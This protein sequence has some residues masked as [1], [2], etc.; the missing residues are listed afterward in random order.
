VPAGGAARG[1]DRAAVLDLTGAWSHGV[2]V[3]SAEW[4]SAA[5]A[6]FERH[7]RLER[8]R[9]EHTVRAYAADVASLLEHAER[10]GRSDVA[11]IDLSVLRS[12]LARLRSQGMARATLARRASAARTFTA[13]AAETGRL[14]A[15]PGSALASPRLGRP[16][17][18]ALSSAQVGEL[19]APAN[20]GS[21]PVATA[22]GRRDTAL[23]ELLYATGARVAELCGAD[24]SDID[25]ERRV[26]R[27]FGK[28]AKERVV[29]F[30]TPAARALHTWI[31]NGRPVL[32]TGASGHALF[33]GARGGRLDQRAARAA[34]TQAA[35]RSGLSHVTPHTLRHSAATHLVEGGADLR[36]VQELLGHASLATTQ[37][38]THVTAER[39]KAT[40]DR[41]HPRA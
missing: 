38:Y 17:P 23:L 31:A 11:S 1:G 36:S 22:L 28:G 10:M 37:I 34:V 33:L 5:L 2:V 41:A 8:G 30:G 14:L 21:E 19:I 25:D 26:L 9:S 24:L 12:W 40:Y 32:A 16:V 35:R 27:V 20:P 13:W 3:T 15:D 6:A 4:G 39:L 29:P 7:L 18:H